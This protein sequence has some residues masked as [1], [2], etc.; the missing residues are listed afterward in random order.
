LVAFEARGAVALVRIASP[1]LNILTWALREQILQAVRRGVDEPG[2]RAIVVGSGIERAFSAG[3]DIHEFADSLRPGGGRER[4]SVEHHTY[5]AIEFAPKPIICAINGFC[6]GG[7]LELAMASDI[8]I[9]GTDAVLGFPEIMLECFPGGG[10]TERL[11]LLVGRARAKELIWTARRLTAEEALSWGLVTSVVSP[12]E[13]WAA[14]ISLATSI[15][16][17]S[18]RAV[19]AAKTLIDEAGGARA[20]ISGALPRVAPWVE[21]MYQSAEVRASLAAFEATK[22]DRARPA[23]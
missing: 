16:E 21:E 6:L 8:R 22:R 4:C 1:P 15:A 5:D 19:L 2:V 11:T 7:G 12:S 18:P 14:A 13:L 17:K 3:A 10:G 9:A 20:D 23:R